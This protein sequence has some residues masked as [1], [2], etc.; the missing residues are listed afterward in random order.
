MDAHPPKPEEQPNDDGTARPTRQ[1]LDQALVEAGLCETRSRAQALIMAGQARLDGRRADKPGQWVKSGQVVTL[2]AV[3]RYVSRG[4]YKL[5]KALDSFAIP[6]AGRRCLDAGISTG[7]FTDCLLQRGA[8]H[9]TGVDVGLGQLAWSLRQDSR[10]TL[11]EKTNIRH[12]TPDAMPHPLPTLAVVDVSFVS[13]AKVIQPVVALLAPDGDCQAEV[14]ALVKP[15]FELQDYVPRAEA[16]GFR[17][18]VRDAALHARIL[19]GLLASLAERLPGWRAENLSFSPI[20][21]PKGN[22]EFLLHMRQCAETDCEAPEILSGEAI[23]RIVSESHQFFQGSGPQ[24]K[25]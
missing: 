12:L 13:L 15:Q 22:T 8:A 18:V 25:V 20:Q 5:E 4:G 21:G 1:R 2:D 14:V 7:G 23:G 9:V 19:E 11:L 24:I 16:K 6:V 10:V 3:E 17:G